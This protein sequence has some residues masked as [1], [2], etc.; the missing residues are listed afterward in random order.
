MKI[1]FTSL[2]LVSS[3]ISHPVTL[4]VNTPVYRNLL[5]GLF[6]G[7][8]LTNVF[9]IFW[10]ILSA[11]VTEA[12]VI[13]GWCLVLMLLFL[14][15][16]LIFLK[17]GRHWGEKAFGQAGSSTVNHRCARVDKKASSY[18]LSDQEA[19]QLREKVDRY[20]WREKPFLKKGYCVDELAEA[21]GASR[22][23]LAACFTQAYDANFNEVINRRRIEYG[24]AEVEPENWERY[25]MEGMAC[26]LGFGSRSTFT[27]SFKRVTGMTPS[28]YRRRHLSGTRQ[29]SACRRTLP[30]PVRTGQARQCQAV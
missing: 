16:V 11:P 5:N 3:G 19:R 6:A 14:P 29:G 1:I 21:V 27:K 22:H 17:R 26:H 24:V 28:Q 2:S 7:S 8:L 20:L 15:I 13:P 12:S 25:T 10:I 30:A 18:W 23:K 9:F 4:S